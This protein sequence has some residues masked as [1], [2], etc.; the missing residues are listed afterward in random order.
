MALILIYNP[1][2]QPDLVLRLRAGIS[3]APTD[4]PAWYRKKSPEGYIDMPFAVNVE[5]EVKEWGL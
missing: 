1:M 2:L 5:E 3:L 4:K